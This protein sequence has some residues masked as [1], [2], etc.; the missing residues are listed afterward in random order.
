MTMKL[1]D[2]IAKEMSEKV[3]AAKDWAIEQFR[4]DHPGLRIDEIEIVYLQG[5]P[6]AYYIREKRETAT[7]EG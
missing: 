2:G 3:A 5:N 4:K 6:Y 1:F 7:D